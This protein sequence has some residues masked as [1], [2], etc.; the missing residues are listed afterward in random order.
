MRFVSAGDLRFVTLTRLTAPT[1]LGSNKAS[2]EFSEYCLITSKRD[3]ATLRRIPHCY[4]TTSI[5]TTFDL[6]VPFSLP[7]NGV[8]S[9]L[10]AETGQ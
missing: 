3:K 7:Q 1:L 9:T 6:I 2:V 8:T 4:R 10:A 5:S